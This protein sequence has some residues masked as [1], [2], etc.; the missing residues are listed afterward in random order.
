MKQYFDTKQLV[1]GFERRFFSLFLFPLFNCGNKTSF[2]F[3]LKSVWEKYEWNVK[4]FLV[5]DASML[6]RTTLVHLGDYLS[7]KYFKN[8]FGIFYLKVENSTFI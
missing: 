5:L 6:T 4:H 3:I 8:I 2:Y 7:L 1:E